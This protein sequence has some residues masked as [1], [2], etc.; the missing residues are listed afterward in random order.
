MRF[1]GIVCSVVLLLCLCSDNHFPV[2]SVPGAAPPWAFPVSLC[3]WS[4]IW[5]S[6]WMNSSTSQLFWWGRALLWSFLV[7]QQYNSLF[8]LAACLHEEGGTEYFGHPVLPCSNRH[9]MGTKIWELLLESGIESPAWAEGNYYCILG[10][11][12][13]MGCLNTPLNPSL[14]TPMAFSF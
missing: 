8:S 1:C 14:V 13:W 5:L 11:T 4:S 9:W 2:T 7:R 6:P 3:P 10:W 12:E